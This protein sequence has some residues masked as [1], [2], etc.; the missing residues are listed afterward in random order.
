GHLAAPEHDR[1]LDLR[2]FLEEALH[3]LHLGVVVVRVDLRAELHL[4][5]DDVR[6]SF[7]R[8]LAPLV[9]LVLVLAEVHDLADRRFGVGC[10]LDEVE[11][12]LSGDGERVGEA[13]HSQLRAVGADEANLASANAIVDAGVVCGQCGITSCRSAAVAKT[14]AELWEASTVAPNVARLLTT[15]PTWSRPRRSDQP[16]GDPALLGSVPLPSIVDA[17]DSPA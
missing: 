3:M 17:E 12:G 16:G 14:T 10:D 5:D 1:Q 4:F 11:T 9:L 15:D 2:P 8:F 7:S 6:R 13:S